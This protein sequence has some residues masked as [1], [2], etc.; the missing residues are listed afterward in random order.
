M[1][2]M[3]SGIP[4]GMQKPIEGYI[5]M[6][7]EMSGLDALSLTFFGAIA[8]GT[9]DPKRHVVQNVLVLSKVDLEGL[10]RLAEQGGALGK[11][12]ISAPLIMTPPYIQASL[13]SFPLELLEIHQRHVTALGE[14]Y[15]RDLSFDAVHLRL[16]CE[17]EIK[18]VL[19]GMRQGLL[20]SV[21][22]EKVI[23][24]IEVDVAGRLLR[25]FRGILWL[26]GRK[27]GIPAEEAVS[28]VEGLL[29]RS[30]PGVRAS[31]EPGGR[32]GWE[33]FRSLYEEVEAADGYVESL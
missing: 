14:D 2:V 24:A 9:F 29:G 27:E 21:G 20:V 31:L 15:F 1:L 32:H 22:K 26:K 5:D 30:L 10:R 8:A 7:R 4:E 33:A 13:D 17:R 12:R 23:G 11:Q 19:I 18:S 25:I 6:I 3:I 28:E 16:Q